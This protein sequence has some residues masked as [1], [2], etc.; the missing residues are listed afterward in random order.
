MIVRTKIPDHSI[1]RK[2]LSHICRLN[3]QI[4]I[5][6]SIF[7]KF[8]TFQI[9]IQDRLK[10]ISVINLLCTQFK[11]EPHLSLKLR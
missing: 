4:A 1:F 6:Y 5:E 9:R 8:S 7:G 3:S 10:K 11:K 2:L